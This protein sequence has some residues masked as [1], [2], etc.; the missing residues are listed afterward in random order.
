MLK[1][2]KRNFKISTQREDISRISDEE[3]EGKPKTA[4]GLMA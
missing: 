3:M 2:P 1:I 4:T